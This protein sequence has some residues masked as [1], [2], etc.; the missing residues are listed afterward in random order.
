MTVAKRPWMRRQPHEEVRLGPA[1]P[2]LREQVRSEDSLKKWN[3]RVV[4]RLKDSGGLGPK[5]LAVHC[6]HLDER[7]LDLLAETNTTVVH[8]RSRT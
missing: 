6:I 1:H 7:E 4:Q 3:K 2:R 8:N 5:T